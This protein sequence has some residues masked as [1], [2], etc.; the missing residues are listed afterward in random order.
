MD[1][2]SPESSN[3]KR[4]GALA[5]TLACSLYSTSAGSC[6]RISL[7]MV[8]ECL[9][10]C[11]AHGGH[12]SQAVS[13]AILHTKLVAVSV[14]R[15]LQFAEWIEQIFG[16]LQCTGQLEE[17]HPSTFCHCITLGPSIGVC[18]HVCLLICSHTLLALLL[19]CLLACLLCVCVCTPPRF[20]GLL[21]CVLACLLVGG[22]AC[23]VAS[24]CRFDFQ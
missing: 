11:L 12:R 8:A 16:R 17:R 21:A 24:S 6:H 10:S 3:N 9:A 22:L 20:A 19:A 1:D 13:H 14:L 7:S 23:R 15:F 18:L 4:V 5:R 2:C